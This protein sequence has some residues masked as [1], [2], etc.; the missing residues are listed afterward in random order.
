M[1]KV[2]ELFDQNPEDKESISALVAELSTPRPSRGTATKDTKKNTKSEEG[3]EDVS[4]VEK[5]KKSR[6][7]KQK[8]TSSEEET[9]S[10]EEKTTKKKSLSKKER[11]ERLVKA[12]INRADYPRGTRF[13]RCIS[14]RYKVVYPSGYKISEDSQ[15]EPESSEKDKG[16]KKSN[17]KVLQDKEKGHKGSKKKEVTSE[18]ESESLSSLEKGQEGEEE[19]DDPSIRD[20]LSLTKDLLKRM[21]SLAREA[22]Q[23]QEFKKSWHETLTKLKCEFDEHLE[24]LGASM[25]E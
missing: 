12:G 5:P 17:S 2:L 10:S 11:E 13:V 16:S 20:I 18:D 24:T 23:N 25:D 7:K 19:K 21:K 6:S 8:E 22:N 15:E 9:P 14:G 1:I 3:N 4:S